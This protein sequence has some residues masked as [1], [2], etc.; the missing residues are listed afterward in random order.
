MDENTQNVPE[1]E[2]T[3]PQ[4]EPVEILTDEQLDEIRERHRYKNGNWCSDYANSFV[5]GYCNSD[6]CHK[7]FFNGHF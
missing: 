2:E 7:Y 6:C 3:V 4:I 1:N 5:C